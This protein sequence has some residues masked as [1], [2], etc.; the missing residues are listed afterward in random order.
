M[1]KRLIAAAVAT[2][3]TLTVAVAMAPAANAVNIGS[4]EGCTP[5]YWKNHT[6]SWQ[7]A[8]PSTPFIE[9]FRA[10]SDKA[11][12]PMTPVGFI[13]E[14]LTMLERAEGSRR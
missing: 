5:G 9:A 4:T 8:K 14:D 12:A 6:D 7:E 10:E 2:L 11:S 1:M 3:M 13:S